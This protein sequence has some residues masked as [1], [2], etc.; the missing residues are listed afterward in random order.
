MAAGASA[1]ATR[2]HGF[3]VDLFLTRDHRF[4]AVT[5]R[6]DSP[7][8]RPV[9]CRQS[10]G[11]WLAE[12]GKIRIVEDEGIHKAS[13]PCLAPRHRLVWIDAPLNRER[14]VATDTQK[15]EITIRR[16]GDLPSVLVE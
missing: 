1:P 7:K 15:P 14:M 16:V 12:G 2:H 8:G 5:Y 3:W 10:S 11:H 9:L 6:L 4:S 13:L